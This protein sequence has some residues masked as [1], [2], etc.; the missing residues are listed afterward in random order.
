MTQ[1]DV[2]TPWSAIRRIASELTLK[3]AP[4]EARGE[5]GRCDVAMFL[6]AIR[7]AREALSF[8]PQ[9]EEAPQ[10]ADLLLSA[11]ERVGRGLACDAREL[12]DSAAEVAADLARLSGPVTEKPGV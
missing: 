5:I 7:E 12:A 3:Y 6:E 4:P 8:A 11:F 1:Q 9:D 2:S 10:A